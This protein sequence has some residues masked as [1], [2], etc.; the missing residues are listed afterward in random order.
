MGLDSNT[1][2]KFMKVLMI[3]RHAKSSWDD[4]DLSDFE[5]PLNKRGIAV[6]PSPGEEMKKLGIMPNIILSSPAK[7]AKQTADIVKEACGFSGNITYIDQIYEASAI[8]LMRVLAETTDTADIALIIGHNPGLENL[9]RVL[10]GQLQA[11]PTAALAKINLDI[12]NWKGLAPNSG[13]L[14]FLLRP[15]KN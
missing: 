2:Q 10:T 6:A 15:N 7:R 8:T 9:I 5:R 1:K 12:E 14:D 4:P 3:L 11:M 13:K